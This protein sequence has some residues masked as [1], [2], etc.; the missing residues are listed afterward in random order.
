MPIGGLE[1]AFGHAPQRDVDFVSA[2]Y[3]AS[4][5]V[6]RDVEQYW[7]QYRLVRLGDIDKR[8]A[9]LAAVAYCG[10]ELVAVS[11]AE[12]TE[13]MN[14][15]LLHYRC[16]VA[17]SYRRREVTWRLTNFTFGLLGEWALKH[18]EDAYA[19]LLVT[20]EARQ[21]IGHMGSPIISKHGMDLVFI[22]RNANGYQRRAIWFKH[23]NVESNLFPASV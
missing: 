6:K 12:P 13:W 4:D 16:S 23:A 20:L 10:K 17:P 3:E 9:E 11:T 19:G 8:T 7:Y 18:P 22:G 15:R 14:L 2:W 5:T 21:F 1:C